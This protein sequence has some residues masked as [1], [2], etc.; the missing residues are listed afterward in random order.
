MARN[1]D[2]KYI[3]THGQAWKN[4]GKSPHLSKVSSKIVLHVLNGVAQ[5]PLIGF[6]IFSF[7]VPASY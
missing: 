5:W 1:A 2:A 4:R 3:F 7:D 6:K